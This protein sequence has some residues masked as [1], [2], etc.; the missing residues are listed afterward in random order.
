MCGESW[1]P[2]TRG[3]FGAGSPEA[4]ELAGEAGDEDDYRKD[5]HY[6]PRHAGKEEPASA[7]GG[8][9]RRRGA[10]TH[11]SYY[12]TLFPCS[13]SHNPTLQHYRLPSVTKCVERWSLLRHA[14]PARRQSR[15]SGGGSALWIPA[16][17]PSRRVKKPGAPGVMEGKGKGE[18]HRSF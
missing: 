2:R 6:H 14:R 18:E 5:G 16:F 9:G 3:S 1:Y 7:Q 12:P 15:R 10:G 11:P 17:L 13:F 4:C 8:G